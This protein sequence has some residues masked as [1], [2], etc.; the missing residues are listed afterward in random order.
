MAKSLTK[1]KKS[2]RKITR[3]SSKKSKKNNN[4]NFRHINNHYRGDRIRKKCTVKFFK[5]K[6]CC[7]KKN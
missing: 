4:K 7:E 1:S 3:K 5:I 2:S 6:N